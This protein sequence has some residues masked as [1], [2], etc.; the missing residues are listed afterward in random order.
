[1][2][3]LIYRYSKK[4]AT[5]IGGTMDNK[6]IEMMKKLIEEKK[7]KG[8]HTKNNRKADNVIGRTSKGIIS[9][10]GGGMFDK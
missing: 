5:K 9:R 4:Q 7:Q 3:Q 8:N 2:F 1:M 6:N 10:N